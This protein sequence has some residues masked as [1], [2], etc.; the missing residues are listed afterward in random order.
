MKKLV[1][2][3]LVVLSL[4]IFCFSETY[5][6]DRAYL[7]Y[8]IDMTITQIDEG[9]NAMH[10]EAARLLKEAQAMGGF[11]EWKLNKLRWY[12]RNVRPHAP[13]IDRWR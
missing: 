2:V 12:L 3:F 1:V 9:N 10:W 11:E 7:E 8:W 13:I 5:A 4:G 6:N